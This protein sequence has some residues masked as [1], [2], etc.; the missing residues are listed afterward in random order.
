M[1]KKTMKFDHGYI[2]TE[3]REDQ[4]GQPIEECQVVR[5]DNGRFYREDE[6]TSLGF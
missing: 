5:A 6:H 1:P 3:Y 2:V 4:A